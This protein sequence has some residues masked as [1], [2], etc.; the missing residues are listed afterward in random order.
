MKRRL[1]NSEGNSYHCLLTTWF[2]WRHWQEDNFHVLRAGLVLSYISSADR[3]AFNCLF[4]VCP[5]CYLFEPGPVSAFHGFHCLALCLCIPTQPWGHLDMAAF[6][7]L[8]IAVTRCISTGCQLISTMRLLWPSWTL[9]WP[10]LTPPP[11]P[12]LMCNVWPESIAII[13]TRMKGPSVIHN[14]QT[15]N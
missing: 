3:A 5:S 1:P 15:Y 7:P 4:S 11:R 9:L 13:K 6:Q 2:V 8:S 14:A 10:L 12:C